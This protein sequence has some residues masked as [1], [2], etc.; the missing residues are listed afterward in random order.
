MT[1]F[2]VIKNNIKYLGVTQASKK[3]VW[4]E[5]QVSEERNQRR[6]KDFSCS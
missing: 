5:L 1:P 4:Q 6:W 3:S 2:T